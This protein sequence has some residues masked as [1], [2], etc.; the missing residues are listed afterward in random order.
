MT[1]ITDNVDNILRLAAYQ[2]T[3]K[4]KDPV[5]E[6]AAAL[7]FAERYRDKL[8]FDY[9]VGKWFV[10]MDTHWQRERTGLAF[11]W[12]RDLARELARKQP[13]EARLAS[14]KASFAGNV[15]RFARSDRTF[16][17]TSEIWDQ[18]IYLLGTPG[19]T[20]D[21]R[22]GKIRKAAPD[23][24]ITKITAVAPSDK[25]ECPRWLQFMREATNN[26]EG[27]I[28]FLQQ[29]SGYMLSGDTKE[30]SL[31]FIHGGGGNGKSV[32]LN[33]LAGILAAYAKSAAMDTFTAS[34]MDK[35]P[36]DLAMLHGARLVTAS[37]TEEGRAWAESRIKQMTGGDKIEARFM[38]QDFFEY[39]P[40]FKL[41]LVGNHQP[42]LR[43]VDDA[44]KRR[45]N[46]VPF[47]HKP[48]TPDRNL[49]AKLR[50]EWPGILRWMIDGCLDWQ[51]NGLTRPQVVLD[52]TSEYFTEQDS[53]RQ[54]IEERCETGKSTLTDTSAN[55]FRSWTTW[56]NA[57]GEKPG[58]AKWFAQ[59]L[60]AHGFNPFRKNKARGFFGIEAKP[61]PV[62]AHY[63]DQ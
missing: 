15:E 8:R 34:T 54:W 28:A 42:T 18:D 25:P 9:D 24:F 35:H 5:T 11:S 49:E 13:D 38:K 50:A 14:S 32:F 45:F 12:A 43:N 29:F 2:E 37:E 26:D 53:I 4:N 47:I 22:T 7:A 55:L 20:V 61:E 62:R 27:L 40:Q 60:R 23:D 16:A 36:T 58:T 41:L 48:P 39:I 3:A 57:N 51:K 31:L 56:A 63:A 1:D 17:V 30:H 46:I 6:D 52:A 21:L 10:W 44:A 33:T 19:G 59:A